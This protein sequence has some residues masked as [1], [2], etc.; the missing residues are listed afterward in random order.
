MDVN[1]TTQ[2]VLCTGINT[3]VMKTYFDFSDLNLAGKKVTFKMTMRLN[4]ATNNTSC[5]L[6]VGSTWTA[7]NYNASW[8]TA[9]WKTI[10]ETFTVS[11]NNVWSLY[12]QGGAN[13]AW[14]QK[15]YI[16]SI[17]IIVQK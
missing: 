3:S 6:Y 5:D 14:N 1:G 10:S 7:G 11:N 13:Y 16:T 9:S 8:M 12:R 2:N 15:M 17:E 4:E